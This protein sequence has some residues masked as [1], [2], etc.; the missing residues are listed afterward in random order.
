MFSL[1]TMETSPNRKGMLSLAKNLTNSQ[2]KFFVTA[3]GNNHEVANYLVD[4]ILRNRTYEELKAFSDAGCKVKPIKFDNG[5]FGLKAM[6]PGKGGGPIGFMIGCYLGAA[7]V[8]VT[9][10]G[11]IYLAEG[12]A[13]AG[14]TLV[15]GPAG[16]IAA[17]TAATITGEAIRLA[18][19]PAIQVAAAKAGLGLGLTLMVLIP[20]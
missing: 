6:V 14:G 11:A 7:T 18:A 16:G 9:A 1:N 12:A 4:P 2:V 5:K 3:D 17:G 10:N 13:A 19:Q 8:N 20:I 15:G